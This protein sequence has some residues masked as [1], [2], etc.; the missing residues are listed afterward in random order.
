M[1]DRKRLFSAV[2][3]ICLFLTGVIFAGYPDDEIKTDVTEKGQRE[4]EKRQERAGESMDME[5]PVIALT[6]D[7]GPS[8]GY[9]QELLDG[10][11]ERD[12]K[13]TF[14]ILGVNIEG[15]EDLVRRMAR[16]GH[17]LG[18][19][20]QNHVDLTR[21]PLETAKEQI[22]ETTETIHTLTGQESTYIRPPYGAWNE[23]L[24]KG[25][26]QIPVAWTVDSLDW[27]LQNTDAIVSRVL[28][29]AEDGD[30]ILMHDCYETTVEAAFQIIDALQG[31]GYR[32]VTVDELIEP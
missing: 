8:A 24:E 11:M 10:L 25:V 13:A 29:D 15:H 3:V 16:E 12:V 31:Q 23:V 5:A 17:L 32:F 2:F 14:F 28:K 6:F 22:T 4:E 9:T 1:G 18:S 20:T 27:S 19:H 21:L 30:I 26:S 7:D